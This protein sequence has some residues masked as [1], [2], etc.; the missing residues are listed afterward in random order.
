MTYSPSPVTVDP[1]LALLAELT[2]RCPLSCLYCYNPLELTKKEQEL[3][4]ETWLRVLEEAAKLGVLQVHLSGGEPLLRPDLLS[5]VQ[6]STDLGLYSNLITSGIGLSDARLEALQNADVG[7][8][9]L[10]FQGADAVTSRE[11]AGGDFFAKKLQVA[12]KVR[13]SDI[14]F[15]VNIVLHRQ[16]L[17]QV[18]DLIDLAASVGAERL[19]LANTQYYGWGLLNRDLLLPSYETLQKAEEVVEAARVRYSEMDIIWV[20]PDYY[21]DY[22]KPCMG[23]WGA[24]QLTVSPNG[25][26]L[27]CPGAYILPD[28]AL[29]S[30]QESSLEHIW[31]D[32]P[33]FNRF[34]GLDWL[35]EPCGS[36]PRKT[37][38]FG[39][40][41]CQAFLLTG[42]AAKT[43]PVCLL[44]PD[45][46]LIERAKTEANQSAIPQYRS[47][48]VDRQPQSQNS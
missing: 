2:H 19:E 45:H 22:P 28:L 30:V 48:K 13:A 31:Y 24:L 12:H 40:C 17:H 34:R 36:C 44:S 6:T 26:V 18:G 8:L 25:K 33:A 3:S 32:S 21:A 41:R 29:P 43:D 11:V 15:S 7:S 5:I 14:P 1:P 27:P 35:P 20:I 39:G 42:D 16:N 9:Q 47:S 10:S 4:T 46:H 23:G 37:E 38:D